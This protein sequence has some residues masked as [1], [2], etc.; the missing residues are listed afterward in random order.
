MIEFLGDAILAV[1]GASPDSKA[2]IEEGITAGIKMQKAMAKVNDY[3]ISK[4]WC[5]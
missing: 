3:I 2:Q 1:F 5:R 4:G